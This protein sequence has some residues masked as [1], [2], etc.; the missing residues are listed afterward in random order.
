MLCTQCQNQLVAKIIGIC[1]DCL[2]QIPESDLSPKFHFPVREKF[3]LP[4]LPPTASEGK[5]CHFCGNQCQILPGESG[6]CGV[7]INR[8][9][10]ISNLAPKRSALAHMYHDPLPTNCCATWFFEGSKERGNNLAVFFYGCNFNCLFCQNSSHKFVKN[11]ST[12]SEERMVQAALDPSVRCVC[13][14]GGSPEPHLPFAIRVSRRI[15]KESNNS[16]RICWEWNGCGNPDLVI[17]SFSIDNYDPEIGDFVVVTIVVK[18]QGTGD[19]IGTFWVDLYYNLTSPP[20]LGDTGDVYWDIPGLDAGYSTTITTTVQDWSPGYWDSYVQ[21]D[22]DELIEGS[23]ETNNVYGPV[24]I[25]WHEPEIL[26]YYGWPIQSQFSP[27]DV[28]SVLN[29][30]RD[31][32]DY[33]F[34]NGID[35]Q[36]TQGTDVYSVSSGILEYQY[37]QET[38]ELYGLSVGN[39]VYIHLEDFDP[40]LP[41][42]NKWVTH[43]GFR[44]AETNSE[45][46]VHFVDGP[47][48]DYVNPLRDDGINP[49]YVDNYSPEIGS[50][51]IKDH[52][53]G[54]DIDHD[55]VQD[56]VD[57]IVQVKDHIYTTSHR[58]GIYKLGYEIVGTGQQ[59]NS[60]Q[61]DRW[62]TDTYFSLVFPQT[63]EANPGYIYYNVTNH[64][65]GDNAVVEGF[66]DSNSVLDG[67]YQVRITAEDK[68][69]NVTPKDFS[70]MVDNSPEMHQRREKK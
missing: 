44:L 68:A 64:M 12:I 51:F 46:H 56:T 66:W 45:N 67:T 43:A 54:D 25:R 32:P 47:L 70:I 38:G 57:F 4:I 52:E 17:Q 59:V 39:F 49:A 6:Y 8:D 58:N 28:N 21:V 35:I 23:D 27:H 65:V 62:L 42:P 29:E 40:N 53:T 14:F 69:G 63:P 7:R 9:G 10:K 48:Y 3:G 37:N 5:L 18:N 50:L 16:K 36:A 31:N 20:L 60:Y 1:A 13:F 2:R 26:D 34:H 61:F 30:Y 15:I 24:R 55:N 11:A 19:A 22:S 41:L 33:H